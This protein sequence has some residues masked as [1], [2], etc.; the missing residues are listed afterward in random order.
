MIQRKCDKSIDTFLC[1]RYQKM[2]MQNSLIEEKAELE[3]SKGREQEL[4]ENCR[5]LKKL[6]E[7]EVVERRSVSSA[8]EYEKNLIAMVSN[9]QN[10]TYVNLT[11]YVLSSPE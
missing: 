8:L 7:N 9:K 10:L 2:E 4:E 3:A 6:L 11:N 1:R 5:D